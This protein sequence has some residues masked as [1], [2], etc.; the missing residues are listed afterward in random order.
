MNQTKRQDMFL[1]MF[2]IKV[3]TVYRQGHSEEFLLGP[4]YDQERLAGA[5]NR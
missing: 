1:G 5:L 3:F 2:L 4:S